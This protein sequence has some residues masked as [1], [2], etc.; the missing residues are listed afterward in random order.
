MWTK[1]AA[2]GFASECCRI[3]RSKQ[4]PQPSEVN[5]QAINV[6]VLLLVLVVDQIEDEDETMRVRTGVQKPKYLLTF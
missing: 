5:L 4:C 2:T 1:F 6:R 3:V